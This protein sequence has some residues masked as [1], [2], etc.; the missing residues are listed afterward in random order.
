MIK[1]GFNIIDAGCNIGVFSIFANHNFPNSN[2][3]AFEPNNVN[4]GIFKKT[5]DINHLADRIHVFNQA[6]GDIKCNKQLKL[7]KD[8]LASGSAIEDSQIIQNKDYFTSSFINVDVVAIDDFVKGNNI[9]KI[10][11]IK[12]DS[13]GYEKNILLGARNTIQ[14]FS[15]I[16]VCSAYHLKNDKVEIP[17]LIRSIS[18]N[19]QFKIDDKAEEILIARTNQKEI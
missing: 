5:I 12:I 7:S 11:F 1:D 8:P 16:I 2:I 6:L 13:E 9:S 10:D 3:Y 18:G 4:F 15:P 17:N 19:Y 14:R